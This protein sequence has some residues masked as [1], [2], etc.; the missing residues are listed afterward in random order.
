M[1][2]DERAWCACDERRYCADSLGIKK[3]KS[4]GEK[5][6]RDGKGK[7]DSNKKKHSKVSRGTLWRMNCFNLRLEKDR[8]E[9]RRHQGHKR[10]KSFE[11]VLFA[12]FPFLCSLS[13]FRD[14]EQDEEAPA[15]SEEKARE[16]YDSSPLFE[17][18]LL[19]DWTFDDGY[20]L[21]EMV[22]KHGKNW[23]KVRI[24]LDLYSCLM[25]R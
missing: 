22:K 19:A 12:I 16:E 10:K 5:K 15:G 21:M 14:A 17:C 3:G 4:K 25:P 13:L 6:L 8:E 9:T 11:G 18:F 2:D 7:P 20:R 23:M 24:C 1:I